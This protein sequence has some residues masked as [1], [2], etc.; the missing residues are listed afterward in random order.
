MGTAFLHPSWGHFWGQIP[1]GR[2]PDTVG[3]AWGPLADALPPYCARDLS[4][5]KQTSPDGSKETI[6]FQTC[7]TQMCL[8]PICNLRRDATEWDVSFLLTWSPRK[9]VF[10][11]DGDKAS[12]HD[13]MTMQFSQSWWQ[14]QARAQHLLWV[15][16]GFQQCTCKN[17]FYSHNNSMLYYPQF[18]TEGNWFT[19]KMWTPGVSKKWT[20]VS[21]WAVQ[22][23]K[24]QGWIGHEADAKTTGNPLILCVIFF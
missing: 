5:P 11:E 21:D 3:L 17:S 4:S 24:L 15:I 7:T 19:E 10:L 8:V 18:F 22:L 1:W 6:F 23:I 2:M 16:W 14:W 9:L 13:S 20:Q 12:S